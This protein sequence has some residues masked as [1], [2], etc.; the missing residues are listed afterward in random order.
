MT[1]PP[2]GTT[3]LDPDES[4]GLLPRH[5][6][7]RGELDEWENQ[8]IL[9]AAQWLAGRRRTDL[10]TD[11]FVRELHRRMFDETWAWA[12]AYRRSDKN[13][14]LHWPE[15]PPAVRNLCEDATTW[16]AKS[17]FPT[18]QAAA[19]L[20][21]RFVAIHCFPNG[22]GRHARLYTDAVLDSMEQVPFEWGRSD[23]HARG[24]ARDA[25]L[26]ALRA[27]DAGDYQELFKFLG[28]IE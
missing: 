7:T 23:L 22:N 6:T 15:I 28:C 26:A 4:E 24:S 17:V 3:P 14:G 11:H 19:R 2:V 10:L 5:I 1:E 21:H 25:Y 13:I 12:G 9:Q 27:A 8:N 18:R 20:H 16:F